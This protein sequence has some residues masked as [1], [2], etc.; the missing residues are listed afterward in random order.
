MSFDQHAFISY[1]HLDNE[2]L[3][4][5]Q[6]GWVTQFHATL[7]TMLSQRIG[8]PARIWRDD[9]LAGN[10]IFSD[11]ILGQFE[12]T[13]L[14]VFVLTP[15]Y[16]KSEW[17]TREIRAFCES[18]L[19]NGGLQIR[20]KSRVF[21][22]V[23]IPV[24]GIDALP[25]AARQVLGYDFYDLDNGNA[26]ELDPA[27]GDQSRQ[28]F[29]RKIHE[30]AWDIA[31]L[32]EQF[33]AQGAAAPLA[34][35]SPAAGSAPPRP[36]KATVFLAEVG[37]D[38]QTAR[39]L[40]EADLKAHGYEILP[41][42]PLPLVEEDLVAE[43]KH[44]FASCAFSIHLIGDNYGVV[45]DGPSERSL[46]ML[47]NEVAAQT[48]RDGTLRRVI[49][50]PEGC[51]GTGSRQQAFISALHGDARLQDGADLLTGDLEQLK[52]AIHAALTQLDARRDTGSDA[53]SSTGGK[54]VHVL[55]D[56]Q[57]RKEVVPLL[58]SLKA[59]GLQVS[60]PVFTGE[61]SALRQANTQLLNQ[62]DALIL[63]YGAGDEAWKFHQQNEIRKQMGLRGERAPA[64]QYLYLA[65][66][67]TA[68]KDLLL[69][70][71]EPGLVDAIDGFSEAALA[72]LL[73]ALA[74]GATDP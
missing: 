13:A 68:D 21:K 71:G 36:A 54:T 64:L 49:W 42:A 70:L 20:N 73:D 29:L 56:E 63:F 3:T 35:V 43:L 30:L 32:C 19:R 22:V 6:K 4:P 15:R 2:P 7:R 60:I 5:D 66:P 31:R 46:A 26:R 44:Q 67:R 65:G 10:D 23:K 69:S 14:L 62:C 61:A 28:A 52:A 39:E 59:R 1:A 45:P 51:T 40:I 41:A 33:E 57:D 24:D 74:L 11:E 58:K 38:R 8:S 9:K 18:A 50:L 48:S 37:R 27:Y 53:M 25:E 72:P 47:Q 55:I 34:T 16:L 17:C 12:R